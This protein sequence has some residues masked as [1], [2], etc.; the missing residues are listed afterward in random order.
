MFSTFI[1]QKVAHAALNFKIIS[2]VRLV[3]ESQNTDLGYG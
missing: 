2:L 1:A 3:I